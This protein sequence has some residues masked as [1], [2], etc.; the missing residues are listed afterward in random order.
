MKTVLDCAC[1]AGHEL[2]MFKE[3][4]CE[5]TGSDLSPAMLELARDNLAKSDADIP[6]HR[7]DYRSLPPAFDGQFD[8]VVCWSGSIF[9]VADDADAL[10]AFKSMHRVLAPG[11]IAV[12]DQGITD[13]RWAAK[14]RFSL[15]RSSQDRSRVYV[16][17]Y[18]G[19]RDCQY[20]VLDI[21][22]TDEHNAE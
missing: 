11:G 15:T 9:H 4:G 7:A 13:R 6:L 18:T 5:P 19:D 17:D 16:V 12:L 10:R 1:G 14:Q 2:L 3:L 21:Q 22:H 8:A 20:H